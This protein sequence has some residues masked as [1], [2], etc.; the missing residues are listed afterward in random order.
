M[1]ASGQTKPS[2][3][4]EGRNQRHAH[5]KHNQREREAETP[6]IAKR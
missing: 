5:E 1:S 3:L 4:P 6:I 2:D